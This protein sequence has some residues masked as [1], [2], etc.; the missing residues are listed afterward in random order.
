MNTNTTVKQ[1][2]PKI[3]KQFWEALLTIHNHFFDNV[4]CVYYDARHEERIKP[5]LESF[6]TLDCWLD[7]AIEEG[8]LD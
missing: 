2:H 6:R 5:V 1:A 4:M 8:W 3:P 7:V